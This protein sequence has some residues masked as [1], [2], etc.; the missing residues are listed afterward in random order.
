MVIIL[1]S[2]YVYVN[3]PS[4]RKGLEIKKS[5]ADMAEMPGQREAAGRARTAKK[6]GLQMRGCPPAR[7]GLCQESL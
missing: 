7:R 1:I 2:N 3:G 4:I 6:I 5:I